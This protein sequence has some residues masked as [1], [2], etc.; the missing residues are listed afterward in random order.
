MPRER[1]GEKAK[2]RCVALDYS[3]DGGGI[4]GAERRP[5][6]LAKLE[7]GLGDRG[8]FWLELTERARCQRCQMPI[9]DEHREFGSPVLRVSKK[10]E[11]LQK[12]KLVVQVLF[13]PQ[14]DL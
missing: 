14:H 8:T 3:G 12:L 5:R 9:N 6:A 11:E 4:G 10:G 7:M 2:R 1:G 13:K